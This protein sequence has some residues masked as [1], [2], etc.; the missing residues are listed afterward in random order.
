MANKAFLATTEEK[1][2]CLVFLL[3]IL[4]FTREGKWNV[5]VY[6]SVCVCVFVR[7]TEMQLKCFRHQYWQP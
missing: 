1:K 4:Y 6:D 5:Y 7:K 3:H 2:N